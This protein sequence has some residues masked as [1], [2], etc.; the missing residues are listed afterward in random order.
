MTTLNS[1]L[2]QAFR[3]HLKKISSYEQAISLLNWDSRTG[4]PKKGMD[5][6]ADVSGTMATE[7]FKIKTSDET[8]KFLHAVLGHQGTD[9]SATSKQAAAELKK[10]YDRMTKIPEDEFQEYSILTAKSENVWEEAKEA[11]DFAM[12][13]PYLEKIVEFSRRFAEHWGYESHPYNA[14][15]EDYEPGMTVDKLDAIFAKVREGLI[16]LVEGVTSSNKKPET[17]FLFS[18]FPKGKQRA[19]SLDVL[20]QMTYDFEAGRLDETVHPF[21]IGLN[22]NDVRVTT[23]YDESDFRTAVFGTI[24]EGGHALYEQNIG[25]ELAGTI[26]SDGASMGIHESQ[27]LFW[28]NFVGRHPKFWEKNYELLQTYAPDQFTGVSLHEFYRAIN[29]AKPSLIRIEA[30]EL[31]YCL[32]IILRYEMEKQLIEGSLK[33]KDLPRVWNEKMEEY[34]GVTPPSNAQGVLQ[35]VHWAFGAFGYFPSYALGYI[36]AAQLKAAMDKDLP[37]F[38]ELVEK[39]DL[40]PIREWMTKNIHQYG[41]S[42]TPIELIKEATGEDIN[43]DYLLQYLS[44]KYKDLYQFS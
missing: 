17:D 42:R 44:E 7:L 43:P 27:S 22:P 34:L 32:H 28:E 23:K 11:D 18:T 30:D 20:K 33:V 24:H 21:A 16:P 14:L 29:E 31:T 26:L 13:A 39:G 8:A 41:R 25:E 37:V 9:V 36:Y 1:D 15:L 40:K 19:F 12:F 5:E 4:A 38:D 35:D 3:S 6:R 10:E 2:E